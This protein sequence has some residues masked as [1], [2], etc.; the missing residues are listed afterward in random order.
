MSFWLG[1]N[2]QDISEVVWLA[3]SWKIALGIL[4]GTLAL[5]QLYRTRRGG[6]K[7]G[8]ELGMWSILAIALMVLNAEP[9]L[10]SEIDSDIDGKLIFLVDSSASMQV[11]EGGQSRF[12][13]ATEVV[14]TLSSEL[15]GVTEVF[16]FDQEVHSKEP[17]SL[18][19]QTDILQALEWVQDRNLG[20]ELRGIVLISDGID[21]AG[22]QNLFA[23]KS[24]AARLPEL[25]GPLTI[26][27]IGSADKIFDESVVSVQSGGFA[28]QRTP[29]QLTASVQGRPSSSINVQLLK[30]NKTEENKT[31][32]L[33]EEGRAEV[34]FDI[35]P[36]DVGRFAWEVQI[37][38]DSA[39]MVPSNNYF[40]VVIKVVRDEVR[41]LQVSGSPSYDQ[42][43]LRL[44]LKEDPS[45]D[46]ISFFI[47]RT[48]QDS[49]VDWDHKELSLIS[50]PYQRLFSTDLDTF[51]LVIFQNF[52]HAP[53]FGYESQELLSNIAEYVKTGGAFIMTGGNLSFDLGEY[54]NTPIEDILPIRL[55]T[56]DKSSELKFVPRLSLSGGMHPITK[57][58]NSTEDN[59]KIWQSLPEMDGYNATFGL[60]S[61]AAALLEHPTVKTGKGRPLPI[62]SVREVGEGRTM[63][64]GIDSSWRWSYSE[65]IEGGGN[66]A[67]LRFWKNAIR[68]VIADPEDRS[69][70]VQPSQENLKLGEEMK[71]FVRSRNTGYQPLA[72]TTVDMIIQFPSGGRTEIS[73]QTDQNGEGEV[74]FT[75]TEQGVYLVKAKKAI[76]GDG[77]ATEMVFAVSSRSDEL[78]SLIPNI[79][80]MEGLEKAMQDLDRGARLIQDGSAINPLLNESAV[81]RIPKRTSLEIGAA[82]IIFVVLAFWGALVIFFRRKWGGR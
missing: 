9:Q 21:R 49:S 67:Y 4:L 24:S 56:V 3:E 10:I 80:L 14:N 62:L 78:L 43:F 68:W 73:V 50:F 81:R 20:Q 17:E 28:F 69:I 55:G 82:P 37:P 65:G 72:N 40:P 36:L 16:Y 41:V 7:L 58:A 19:E 32:R 70:V 8:L 63:A 30:N 66:Q 1:G 74:I 18:G 77:L 52:N 26:V 61:G 5:I 57:L 13:R 31:V 60:V 38:V 71:L 2:L 76:A 39:D 53:Y 6:E 64:L 34:N 25:P 47:L 15:G 59:Q 22:L 48:H 33:D 23:S 27:Q 44:F 29:F 35:R 46:L 54:Q 79:S 11:E 12:K 45:V 42:K 75:P 51:D